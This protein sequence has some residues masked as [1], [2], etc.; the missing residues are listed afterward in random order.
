MGAGCVRNTK[1][2]FMELERSVS[3]RVERMFE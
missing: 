1:T 2:R 3:E